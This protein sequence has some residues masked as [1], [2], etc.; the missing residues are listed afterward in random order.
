MIDVEVRILLQT[1]NDKINKPFKDGF[2]FRTG[3]DPVANVL[4][5]SV[6]VP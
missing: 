5:R 6:L 4:L 2:L 3:K 1:L